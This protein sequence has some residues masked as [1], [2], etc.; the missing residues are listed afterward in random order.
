M[1]GLWDKRVVVFYVHMERRGGVR[2]RRA[3]EEDRVLEGARDRLEAGRS[4]RGGRV[5]ESNSSVFLFRTQITLG[6]L[7][8]KLS[9]HFVR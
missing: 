1:E 2:G 3:E 8:P 7:L 6:G 5:T 9:Q 4:G